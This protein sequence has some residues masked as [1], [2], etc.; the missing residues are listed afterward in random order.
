MMRTL[1]QGTP[2]HERIRNA[3]IASLRDSIARKDLPATYTLNLKYERIVYDDYLMLHGLLTE[4][5]D[6]T[7][8]VHFIVDVSHTG[9]SEEALRI[10]VCLLTTPE[11]PSALTLL[12]AGNRM[13][14][15][16]CKHLGDTLRGGFV[17]AEK[18]A[19]DVAHNGIHAEALEGLTSFLPQCTAPDALASLTSFSMCLSG[20]PI[21]GAGLHS[22]GQALYSGILPED[23]TFVLKDVSGVQSA[24]GV[25]S[26]CEGLASANAPAR[27]T[28]G[29]GFELFRGEGLQSL[30]EAVSSGMCQDRLALRFDGSVAEDESC[31]LIAAA[32]SSG[33]CPKE[34]ALGLKNCDIT[35]KGAALLADA[36]CSGMAPSHLDLNVLGNRFGQTG[37]LSFKEACATKTIPQGLRI[38]YE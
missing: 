11:A 23:T 18:V 16:M 25:A 21:G 34:L 3:K 33:S 5:P 31:R 30:L 12:L 26:L 7:K 1:C 14:S 38:K 6:V 4:Q 17:T 36:L 10:V 2:A 28:L 19:I 32:L 24:L 27:L 37:L 13:T 22:I 29:I 35:S 9:L 15:A 8:T 20:N